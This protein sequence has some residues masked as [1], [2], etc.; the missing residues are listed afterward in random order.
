MTDAI[1]GRCTGT[2]SLPEEAA[3]EVRQDTE[4]SQYTCGQPK[5]RPD[6]RV[7]QRSSH[8]VRVRTRQSS[9]PATIKQSEAFRQL[10]P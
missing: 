6:Q 2:R 7:T 5:P 1:L 10:R 9:A 8:P 4:T 3:E